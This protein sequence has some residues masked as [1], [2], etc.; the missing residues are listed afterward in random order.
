MAANVG[1][2]PW[3]NRA[4]GRR[5]Y[6]KLGISTDRILKGKKSADLH[7]YQARADEV[8]ECASAMSAFGTKRTFHGSVPMSAFGGKAD[9]QLI[10]PD[11]CF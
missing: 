5:T 8:I 10:R 2:E 3:A 6:Q 9:I 11:V 4:V 1:V 7:G